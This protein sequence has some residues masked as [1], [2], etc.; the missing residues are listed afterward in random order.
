MAWVELYL[1]FAHIFRKLDMEL[2]D[3]RSVFLK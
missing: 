2:V 3:T 1:F